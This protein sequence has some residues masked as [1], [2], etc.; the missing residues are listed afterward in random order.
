MKT[1]KSRYFEDYTLGETIIHSVPRTVTEGDVSIYLATTGSRFALNYSIE[2]SKKLGFKKIPIDDVLT[3]HLVFGRTVP[4]LSLNA[5][6][7]LGYAG[8]K[9][10][11]PV[12]IG[13]T[14][15]SYSKIIGLKENSNGKTGTVYVETY[16]KNQKDELVLYYNRW[17]MMRKNNLEEHLESKVIPNL[18][19]FVPSSEFLIPENLNIDKWDYLTTGSESF[20]D[21]YEIDEEIHHLDGQTIEEAEHQLATRLYQN[22]ARVHFNQHVEKK[23]RFG[24]RIIYG[25]Y[26]I[27]LARAI[28]CNGFANSIK[29]AAI[30]S[31]KHSAPTFS[32]D[33]IYA[34]S[35]VLEKEKLSNKIGVIKV[36]TLAS[37]NND[38]MI[39]PKADLPDN[40]VL[41][42]VYSILI[43][44]K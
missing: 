6:A 8:V 14:L 21:D 11:K 35:K 41:D 32:G 2:F 36:R 22:N 19:S 17:L 30:H 12:F 40:I 15:K 37:K 44:I 39:F 20:Y 18:Q 34:W 10:L 3:F 16:G 28:S 5:I 25:G 24:K 9:F 1:F 13:D 23:G 26:I 4:D 43:P 42:L 33:T 38:E 27:S 7:N 31:G 29:I